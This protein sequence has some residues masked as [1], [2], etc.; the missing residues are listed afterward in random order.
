MRPI[1]RAEHW[2]IQTFRF[3]RMTSNVLWVAAAVVPIIIG[4]IWWLLG[5]H[6]PSNTEVLILRDPAITSEVASITYHEQEFVL[7]PARESVILHRAPGA[8]FEAISQPTA[9]REYDQLVVGH[10]IVQ[11]RQLD[12]WTPHLRMLGYY[13][14]DRELS[15][16]VSVGRSMQPEE[17]NNWRV[18]AVVVR[19]STIEPVH[20]S[21][22]AARQGTYRLASLGQQGVDVFIAASQDD[23]AA[24]QH[25]R[26]AVD[27]PVGAYIAA[28][29]STFQLIALS[30]RAA[31]ALKIVQGVQPTYGLSREARNV[32]GGLQMIP[33]DYIPDYLVD[34]EFIEYVRQA[35]EQ[36][37]FSLNASADELRV[38]GFDAGGTLVPQEFAQL[39][40]K[41]KFLLHK[42]FRFRED[43]GAALR[44][45]R[46][47]NREGD[48]SYAFV[49]G[50]IENFM[51]DERAGRITNIYRYAAHLTN[52]H[53]IAAEVATERGE[54]FDRNRYSYPRLTAYSDSS[55]AGEPVA[56][57][58]LIPADRFETTRQLNT[59][60]TFDNRVYAA[61]GYRLSGGTTV[62]YADGY[63]YYTQG[64]T[65]AILQDTQE[66]TDGAYTFRYSRSGQGRLAHNVTGEDGDV[67]R[68]YPLGP[69]LAHLVGY[70]YAASQFK[71]NLEKIFDNVLL[72][73]EKQLPWWSLQKTADRAPGNNVILTIDDDLQRVVY[74]ELQKKLDDLNFRYKTDQFKG[75]AVVL[76]REGEILASASIPS[77]DPNAIRPILT[78]LKESSEDHW[79]S[80]FINRATQKS[81][82]PGST[83]KVIMSTIALDNTPRFLVDVG[84]GQYMIRDN[85]ATFV[86]TGWLDSFNGRSFGRYGIPDFGGASHG[87]LTLDTALTKSCNNTFAFLALNA[88]HATIQ[89]YSE[90]YGF[91]QRFDF[92]PYS[93]FKENVQLSSNIRRS[94]GDALSSLPSQV[95]DPDGELKLSQLARMGIGQWEILATPLQMAT[96]AMTVGNL[97]ERPYPH[98]V[99]G[100]QDRATGETTYLP[101]PA[102][103]PAFSAAPLRELIPM[104]QHVVQQGSAIRLT[105][106][107]IDYYPLKDH[108]AGKT[109]TAEQEDE[110]GRKVNVVWFISFAPVENPQLAIAVLIERGRI[111]SG[112]AVEVARGIWEK[113]VLLYPELFVE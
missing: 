67:R 39:N 100:I 44:W 109:G 72:G 24:W 5:L 107:T 74:A 9:L 56:E 41:Q 69:Q 63:F 20:F 88:G 50:N 101:Y 76:N 53:T 3:N 59:G 31:L 6:E 105:R 55:V 13:L 49:P 90:R 104:M 111:I 15:A 61:G 60:R 25:V 54:I 28:G 64:E 18:N 17:A 80:A 85:G 19:D 84:D 2:I 12:D 16:G 43:A 110:T 73:K 21:L 91:N 86:C 57:L 93:M 14:P 87:A 113:A 22:T 37:L 45:R 71:G 48:D 27:I 78:A 8:V 34:E 32:V 99:K 35:I 77:Y 112:E 30:G 58:L 102:K 1:L 40:D 79:N 70:S 65:T 81:Y 7:T 92:L 52:P 4:M 106:S 82:P 95:P 94:V 51:I 103:I 68:Y 75:A 42:I 62:S 10:A 38:K 96:V 83:M 23:S 47:F 66:F 108:V 97:G 11:V 36:G 33:E 26:D 46:P 29:S 98:L 89:T